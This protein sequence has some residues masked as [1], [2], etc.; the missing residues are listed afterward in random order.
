[1]HT[2]RFPRHNAANSRFS[3]LNNRC[4]VSPCPRLDAWNSL[5]I[6]QN[7][8]CFLSTPKLSQDSWLGEARTKGFWDYAGLAT[9]ELASSTPWFC[10][11]YTIDF[12]HVSGFVCKDSASLMLDQEFDC[13]ADVISFVRQ[14]LHPAHNVFSY[15]GRRLRELGWLGRWFGADSAPAA[16]SDSHTNQMLLPSGPSVLRHLILKLETWGL[17]TCPFLVRATIRSKFK[18]WKLHAHMFIQICGLGCIT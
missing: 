6:N 17:I 9:L 7:R 13:M 10:T 11:L 15:W 5:F 16:D 2:S 18:S 4:K 3:E 14:K 12:S 8:H 1:M